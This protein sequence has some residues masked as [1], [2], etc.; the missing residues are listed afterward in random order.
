MN[1]DSSKFSGVLGSIS[2]PYPGWNGW[3]GQGYYFFANKGLESANIISSASDAQLY[4]IA[5]G[6]SEAQSPW[7]QVR[8]LPQKV[9]YQV[10][11]NKSQ[12]AATGNGGSSQ[13][14]NDGG[15]NSAPSSSGGNTGSGSTPTTGTQSQGTDASVGNTGAQNSGSNGITVNIPGSGSG[16]SGTSSSYIPTTTI[17]NPTTSTG[18]TGGDSNNQQ[19]YY[20]PYPSTTIIT[21]SQ[22]IVIPQKSDVASVKVTFSSPGLNLINAL[23]LYGWGSETYP[24]TFTINEYSANGS[25]I[26]S[27]SIEKNITPLQA[28]G[29]QFILQQEFEQEAGIGNPVLEAA[30]AAAA[31]EGDIGVSAYSTTS[32]PTQRAWGVAQIVAQGLGTEFFVM[33]PVGAGTSVA[34]ALPSN[35]A[36]SLATT[37]KPLTTAET[38][39]TIGFGS[40]SGVAIVATAPEEFAGSDLVKYV[41]EKTLRNGIIS[42]ASGSGISLISNT[43]SSLELGKPVTLSDA[44]IWI[45]SGFANGFASGTEYAGAIDGLGTISA[46]AVKA[47]APTISDF[48][49]QSTTL[50]SLARVGWGGVTSGV[51]SAANGDNQQNVMLNALFGSITAEIPSGDTGIKD[52]SITITQSS[53]TATVSSSEYKVGIVPITINLGNENVQV[54]GDSQSAQASAAVIGTGTKSDPYQANPDGTLTWEGSGYYKL[55]AD[56]PQ[57]YG[58][59]PGIYP[60]ESKSF[61]D[62]YNSWVNDSAS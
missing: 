12:T 42:G 20:G 56:I 35:E 47:T 34:I 36:L 2:N 15:G 30:T 6:G 14:N 19:N 53:E 10:V 23:S 27:S 62:D 7:Q 49:S 25:L 44:S 45:G 54:A 26:S 43:A 4:F 41:A 59:S 60:I 28:I 31:S 29:Q 16:Q 39:D 3:Q 5:M 9:N 57:T 18:S 22:S 38:L 32:S 33:D 13:T 37:G 8:G 55:T 11:Q 52:G 40:I 50:K 58:I 51:I 17:T 48:V 21:P 24:I 46:S 1:A 61:V